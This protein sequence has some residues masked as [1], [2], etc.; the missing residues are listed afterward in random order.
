LQAFAVGD[1]V[2][3]KNARRDDRKGG[4][5]EFRWLG[6]YTIT[7]VTKNGLYKLKKGNQYLK[8]AISGNML[9]AYNE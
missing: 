5:Q 9:K 1:K 3:K 2:L 6:P 7:S 8:A 4:K